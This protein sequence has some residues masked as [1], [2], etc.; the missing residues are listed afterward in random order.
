MNYRHG[1]HAGNFADVVKHAVLALLLQALRRKEKPFCYLETH[2]GAGRYDLRSASAQKTGEYRHGIERLWGL[3]DL[4]P[5]LEGYLAAVRAAN[6][7]HT[8]DGAPALRYYPGSPWIARALLGPRDR[9]VLMELHPE[10]AQR[11]KAGF[12]GDKRAHVHPE[13]G[14][15][16]LKA[17]LP[18]AERRGLVF[19]DPP[20]EDPQE[21]ERLAR[22]LLDAHRRWP[23]GIYAAWYPIKDRP[24]IARFHRLVT[25]SGMAKVLTAELCVRPDDVPLTLNG[26]GM[27]L[28]NPPWRLDREL[29]QLLPWLAQRL[30]VDGAGKTRVEWLVPE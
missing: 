19:L 12:A 8:R 2:A 30:R 4:H 1:Y 16:G 9:M 17:L 10:Q 21:F 7:E 20:F 26:C 5:L 18:P 28:V 23:S 24:P 29:E 22:G 27:L 25:G 13:D 15:L 3:A 11:L 6:A 14:Y